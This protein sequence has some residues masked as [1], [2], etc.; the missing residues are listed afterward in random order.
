MHIISRQISR[1]EDYFSDPEKFL[2]ERFEGR[3]RGTRVSSVDENNEKRNVYADDPSEFVFGFGR[4]Y[5]FL[6]LVPFQ[7]TLMLHSQ[8]L[9][10]TTLRGSDTLVNHNQ[11]PC[12]VRHSAAY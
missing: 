8:D 2:P 5:A 12:H 10:G 1:D 9:S 11:C 3:L 7:E 6:Q 4:R